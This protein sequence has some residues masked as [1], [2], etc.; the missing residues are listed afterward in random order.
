MYTAIAAGP[1]SGG[2]TDAAP[3]HGENSSGAVG[4]HVPHIQTSPTPS[5][6]SCSHIPQGKTQTAQFGLTAPWRVKAGIGS[7]KAPLALQAG[8]ST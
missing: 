4:A 6:G 8:K 7:M 1:H 5:D 2:G 3:L